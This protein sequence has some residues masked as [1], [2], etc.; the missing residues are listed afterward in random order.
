[1]K[2]I[3]F[4]T[5]MVR[6]ILDGKK[7]QTRRVIK[8]RDGSLPQDDEMSMDENGKVITVMDFSKDFP[9]WRERKCPY[10]GPGDKLWVRETFWHYGAWEQY[11]D[12]K[13]KK[14]KR[15][16]HFSNE[17]I[18]LQYYQENPH[19]PQVQFDLTGR[20][21]WH[22]RP[23]IYLP[24]KYSRITLEVKDVRVERVQDIADEDA[25]KEGVYE[26]YKATQYDPNSF[27][28]WSPI[29]GSGAKQKFSEL[30]DSIN[31][32]RGYGWDTNP[33]VWVVEFEKI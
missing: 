22:K 24:K 19:K 2:P 11:I 3:I 21:D 16:I 32:K 10:G 30:W 17:D 5:E 1:M 20:A 31:L 18:Y 12:D 29:N 26:W 14:R 4:N 33:W 25:M 27:S 9:Q 23:S 7:N 8:L 13:G 28:Y 15:F 6:A